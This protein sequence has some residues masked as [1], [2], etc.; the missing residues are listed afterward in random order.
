M[1]L[2]LVEERVSCLRTNA[3]LELRLNSYRWS[4]RSGQEGKCMSRKT[5]PYVVVHWFE[6]KPLDLVPYLRP[7]AERR[8][9]SDKKGSW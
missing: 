3:C 8:N 1:Y 7:G 4:V 9:K 2:D 6:L 5:E